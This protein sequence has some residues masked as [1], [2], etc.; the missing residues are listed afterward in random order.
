ML[1]ASELR[2]MHQLQLPGLVLLHPP[3]EGEIAFLFLHPFL[4]GDIDAVKAGIAYTAAAGTL[5]DRC[6]NQ[7]VVVGKFL[8]DPVDHDGIKAFDFPLFVK[9]NYLF[10]DHAFEG[11]HVLRV[12][13]ID[14]ETDQRIGFRYAAACFGLAGFFFPAIAGTESKCHRQEGNSYKNQ[15]LFHDRGFKFV[16]DV[17]K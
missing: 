4:I 11:F 10:G 17:V 9:E 15:V 8:C 5:G 3:D 1:P 12:P 13:G 7:V 16:F 14:K 2:D 6:H